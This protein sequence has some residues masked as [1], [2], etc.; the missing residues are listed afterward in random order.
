MELED[1]RKKTKLHKSLQLYLSK[2]LKKIPPISIPSSNIPANITS[3]RL[4]STCRFPRTPSL[5]GGDHTVDNNGRDQA[6]TLSDVN[7]FL[8][9]NFRS[10]Y[11]HDCDN[12]AR[13]SSSPGTST[14]LINETQVEPR[15][16]EPESPRPRGPRCADA[17]RQA[18]R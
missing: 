7:S 6:A 5:D 8:F 12:N 2:K 9:D 10:L 1:N 11:I 15:A 3:S 4:L 18:P 13:R 14:S 16:V 17:A